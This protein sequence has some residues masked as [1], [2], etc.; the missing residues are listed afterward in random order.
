YRVTVAYRNWR[1]T[2]S[3][4]ALDP[5]GV[6]FHGGRWYVTGHD[7]TRGAV[8]TFRLDRIEAV[9]PRPETF[10][11]PDGFDAVAQV[12]RGLASVPYR[13]PVAVHLA[14]PPDEVRRAIPPTVGTLTPAGE[15]TR[16]DC[17]AENLDGMARLLAGLPWPFTVEEPAELRT[18]LAD[19]A[20]RL[21]GYAGAQ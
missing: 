12:T 16:L 15:G 3:D 14:A 11:V 21:A 18:A 6:V 19:H 5:Y 10:E 7:H 17:R 20:A 1:G 9:T 8:R 13:W 4:R 2:R